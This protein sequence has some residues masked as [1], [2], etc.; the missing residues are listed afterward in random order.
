[1]HHPNKPWKVPFSAIVA[2]HNIVRVMPSAFGGV[3]FDYP[4]NPLDYYGSAAFEPLAGSRA[5]VTDQRASGGNAVLW[6]DPSMI[7]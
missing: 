5:F 3:G 6:R 1:M 7:L 4:R 2:M